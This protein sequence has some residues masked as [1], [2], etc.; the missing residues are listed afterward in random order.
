LRRPPLSPLFSRIAPSPPLRPAGDSV[1]HWRPPV[2]HRVKKKEP[3]RSPRRAAALR[4]LPPSA[5]SCSCTLIP[6]N[7]SRV[8]IIARHGNTCRWTNRLL[9]PSVAYHRN[10]FISTREIKNSREKH[11]GVPFSV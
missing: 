10:L 8:A 9:L 4:P 1:S 2:L 11:S 7:R 6:G 5:L 3:P